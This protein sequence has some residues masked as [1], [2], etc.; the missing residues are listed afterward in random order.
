[1]VWSSHNNAS[2]YFLPFTRTFACEQSWTP[3]LDVQELAAAL[4]LHNPTEPTSR[5]SSLIFSP[6]ASIGP[7]LRSYLLLVIKTGPIVAVP[8]RKHQ[9]SA[10]GWRPQAVCSAAVRPHGAQTQTGGLGA[11]KWGACIPFSADDQPIHWQ[12]LQQTVL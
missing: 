11:R 5:A 10:R 2:G 8:L 7:R 1:M 4:E 6:G 9:V 3:A 12:A